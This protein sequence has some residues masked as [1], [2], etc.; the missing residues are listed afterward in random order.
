[1]RRHHPKNERIKRKYLLHLSE[2]KGRTESTIDQIAAHIADF[3]AF[4]KY[5]DFARFHIELARRYKADLIERLHPRTGKPLAKSTINSRLRA[6]RAFHI[7]LADQAGYRR[8]VK[9]A[10]ADYFNDTSNDQRIA[11]AKR[12]KQ[13]ATIDEVL[14][15]IRSMPAGT[16]IERRNR[17]V[18][19]FAL[20]SG[21]R[22]DAIASMRVGLVDIDA[23]T[24]NQDARYVRTKRRKTIVG[25]FLPV[26]EEA[27]E[28]VCEWVRYL[29]ETRGFGPDDPLFQATEIRRNEQGFFAPAG[30]GHQMWSNADAVRRI[31]REAFA[32]ADLP[33]SNPHTIR[34]TVTAFGQR[35]C[36]TAEDFKAWSMTVGHEDV[37]TTLTSYGEVPLDRRIEVMREIGRRIVAGEER[38]RAIGTGAPDPATIAWVV[39]YLQKQAA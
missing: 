33:Y 11:R 36:R 30:L 38:D 34:D 29:R 39:A 2:A 22:D 26:G 31:F 27:I 37:M 3:E 12:P 8:T 9:H 13:V 6:L 7:W 5:R 16:E 18:V 32:A 19:A 24:I 28:I 14:H 4:T 17:A 10:D 15:V 20:V 21:A 1:M 23:R 25:P 35:H